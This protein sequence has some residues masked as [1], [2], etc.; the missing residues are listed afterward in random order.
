MLIK[1][2]YALTFFIFNWKT[3]NVP[4]TQ[5]EKLINYILFK[6]A[7]KIIAIIFKFKLKNV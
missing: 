5:D 1:G 6:L 7:A 2:I 3:Q 4:A